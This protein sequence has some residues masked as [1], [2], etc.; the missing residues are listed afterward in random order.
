MR[1]SETEKS[2]LVTSCD[3]FATLKQ[4]HFDSLSYQLLPENHLRGITKMV[5]RYGISTTVTSQVLSKDVEFC[6]PKSCRTKTS[7]Y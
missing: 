3:R 1:L 2:K 7:A 5:P 6:L 4:S